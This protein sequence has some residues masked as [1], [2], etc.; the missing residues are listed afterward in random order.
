MKKSETYN[1][2]QIAVITTPTISPENKLEILRVLI[3]D[4]G[5]ALF[6]EEREAKKAVEE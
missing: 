6:S 2:A 5:I 4:E 1:L 3:E